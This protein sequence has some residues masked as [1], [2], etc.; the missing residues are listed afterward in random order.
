MQ[1]RSSLH[2]SLIGLLSAIYF[3]THGVAVAHEAGFGDQ[4]HEHEGVACAIAATVASD[5]ALLPPPQNLKPDRPLSAIDEIDLAQIE[6]ET[7]RFLVRPP[8]R[9]P[10]ISHL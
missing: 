7:V 5:D 8:G 2:L 1:K 6:H 9:A 3:L 10:P 4:P